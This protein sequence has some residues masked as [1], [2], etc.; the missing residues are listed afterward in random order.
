MGIDIGA[1][2]KG[3]LPF[4]ASA[5]PLPPPLGKMASD[6]IA[7]VLGVN[8][9]DKDAVVAGLNNATPEQFKALRQA[10]LDFQA[11]MAEMGFKDAE[12]L[13]ALAVQSAADVNKT[14]QVEATSEHWI[15]YAWRPVIG[16]T[17]AAG[18]LILVITVAICYFQAIIYGKTETLQ[19][20]PGMITAMA[21]IFALVTPIVGIASW[22][23]GKTQLAA[24]ANGN[25]AKT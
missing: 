9:D 20:I 21:A 16:F 2:F 18:F 8:K 24:A 5:L 12:Q 25:G 19:Y 22:F 17:I 6:A 4:L 14:M 15:Q 1:I 13:N 11:K 23:R 10:E 7:G 3:A